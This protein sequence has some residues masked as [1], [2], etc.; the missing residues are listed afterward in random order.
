MKTIK[1]TAVIIGYSSRGLNLVTQ[2]NNILHEV[3]CMLC[4]SVRRISSGELSS[5]LC[6]QGPCKIFFPTYVKVNIFSFLFMNL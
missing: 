3:V 1:L 2:S 4:F 5:A 6:V